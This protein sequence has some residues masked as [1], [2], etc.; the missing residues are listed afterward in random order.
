[1]KCYVSFFFIACLISSCA[2][3]F[4]GTK[5]NLYFKTD[6]PG[7]SVKKDGL[8]ICQTPCGVPVR[9]SWGSTFVTMEKEGYKSNTVLLQKKFNGWSLLN[10][11]NPFAWGI[12][13]ATASI[14]KYDMK[15][16]RVKLTPA[17]NQPDVVA[18]ASPEPVNKAPDDQNKP[19]IELISPE[20][21]RGFK[22]V[23]ASRN[24]TII[25]VVSDDR[26]VSSVRINGN[27]L[28]LS[29]A[30]QFRYPVTLREGD[31][32]F[33]IEAKD[34]SDNETSISLNLAYEAENENVI[35]GQ[36]VIASPGEY[37][38][39]VIGVQDYNDPDINDLS[40]PLSDAR[41]LYDVL[42]EHYTFEKENITFLQNPTKNEITQSLDYYFDKVT[43]E[44]NFLVFY[45]GHGFW[46]E[47]FEQ[48]YWL[49]ADAKNKQRGTWISN[50][51]VR[52]YLRAI[53]SRHSLLVTDACFAG[54]IFK[55]RNAF[56]DASA[57]VTQ[58]HKLPSRKAMTSGALSE[59]PDNSAFIKYMAKRLEENSQRYLPS[60]Q[61]FASFKIA[62][63]NNSSIGQVP[64]YGEIK[65]TGDEGGDFIFIRK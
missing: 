32:S 18:I 37:Y 41:L 27:E 43:E 6:P 56:S 38:A 47:K 7:A 11:W 3:I 63:I 34:A 51:T 44:D 48:G 36:E 65:E 16:Y 42:T 45:A 26:E 29:K 35:T 62:V 23:V 59:V 52:D 4:T 60:E 22:P 13:A 39:L 30:G 24:F 46:D 20:Q 14:L 61:L 31:N 54:G 57:A 8:E 53:P 5:D 19:V 21:S 28:S 25:G 50:S 64:Q 58:L 15:Q 1:M 40:K 17:Q 9:R 2:T 33:I 49:A 12:D 55:S 10:L